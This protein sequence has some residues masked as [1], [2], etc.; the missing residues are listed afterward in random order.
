[1]NLKKKNVVAINFD[2]IRISIRKQL[3]LPARERKYISRIISCKYFE[4]VK[5]EF[6]L[7]CRLISKTVGE[8]GK[9]RF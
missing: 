6:Q 4:L 2:S 7:L 1:M 3:R 8:T 5:V 9:G